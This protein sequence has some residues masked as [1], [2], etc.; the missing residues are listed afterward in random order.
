M[1]ILAPN[2]KAHSFPA[3]RMSQQQACQFSGAFDAASTGK[4]S[5]A[6]VECSALFGFFYRFGSS[7]DPCHTHRISTVFFSGK[8]W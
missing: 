8:I 2:F 1:I 7:L 4:P 6:E 3:T 5:V